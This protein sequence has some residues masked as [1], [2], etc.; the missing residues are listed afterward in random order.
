MAPF[1]LK[2]HVFGQWGENQSTQK[3]PM[4]ACKFHTERPSV[5]TG[6]GPGT[7]LQGSSYSLCMHIVAVHEAQ[8]GKLK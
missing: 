5:R 7:L 6:F 2:M 1:S 8:L 3:K 4:V